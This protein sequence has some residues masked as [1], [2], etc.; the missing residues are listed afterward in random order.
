M[1]RGDVVMPYFQTP[2]MKLVYHSTDELNYAAKLLASTM[3]ALGAKKKMIVQVC[4]LGSSPLMYLQSRWFIPGLV[5]GASEIVGYRVICSEASPERVG[6]FVD[7]HSMLRPSLTIINHSISGLVRTLIDNINSRIII[8]G[9][10][11]EVGGDA[12]LVYS[13]EWLCF[14][15]KCESCGKFIPAVGSNV[16]CEGDNVIIENPAKARNGRYG[17][18]KL[19]KGEYCT[20]S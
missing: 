16:S 4:D 8:A 5:E 6:V 11:D 2:A 12:Q 10:F 19:D 13:S 20:C 18:I 15:H 9:D 14:A 3:R 17:G 7:A 1:H